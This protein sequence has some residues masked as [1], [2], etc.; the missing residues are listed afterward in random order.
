MHYIDILFFLHYLLLIANTDKIISHIS[1]LK[2]SSGC[3]F[4]ETVEKNPST[5]VTIYVYLIRI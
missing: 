1:V 4:S 3:C 5:L 2:R